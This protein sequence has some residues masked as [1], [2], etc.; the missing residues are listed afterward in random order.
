MQV[1]SLT[2]AKQ[3]F[4]EIIEKVLLGEIFVITKYGKPVS[5]LVIYSKKPKR[6][7]PV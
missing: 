4:Y 7:N 3:N 6:K 1:I 5:K 2:K